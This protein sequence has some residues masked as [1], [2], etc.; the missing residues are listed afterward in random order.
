[1]DVEVGPEDKAAWFADV[2]AFICR[3]W[4]MDESERR[5]RPKNT[6]KLQTVAGRDWRLTIDAILM[7]CTGDGLEQFLLVPD[8]SWRVC[9][10]LVLRKT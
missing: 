4:E 7:A 5:S 2:E 9:N 3:H 10:I 1:M 6:K 8:H